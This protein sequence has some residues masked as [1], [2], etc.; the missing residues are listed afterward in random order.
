MFKTLRIKN[1][2]NRIGEKID[3]SID[4]VTKWAEERLGIEDIVQ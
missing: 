1:L 4:K 3:T 2:S